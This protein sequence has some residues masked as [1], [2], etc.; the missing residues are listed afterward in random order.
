[1]PTCGRLMT[2]NEI[3][4]RDA[5]GF[6][7]VNVPP[8]RSSGASLRAC[9]RVG[10]VA[11]RGGEGP[12]PQAVG[13][14]HDGYDESL[15]IEVD[16]DSEMHG[17]MQDHRL[18]V[19]GGGRVQARV[20]PQRVDDG[21]GDERERGEALGPAC[22]V[23]GRVVGGDDGE[24]VRDRALRREEPGCGPPA[25]VVER[26]HLVVIEAGPGPGGGAHVGAGDTAPAPVP[27]QGRG[28]DAGF[29]GEIPHRG[30]DE[31]P[32]CRVGHADATRE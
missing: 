22:R 15:E 32:E 28:I 27:D 31:L 2:G 25:D 20:L 8:A 24:R 26:D 1:M 4:V 12:Q 11:D 19:V 3:H 21:A 6:V 5:P 7:I 10:D 29:A 16:G 9:A 14:V 17:A 18:P 13:V 30:R 23:D